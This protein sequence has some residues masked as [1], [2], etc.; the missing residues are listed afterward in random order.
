MCRDLRDDTATQGASIYVDFTPT[1]PRT[2]QQ[3]NS[4]T[5]AVLSLTPC[6]TPLRSPNA[7]FV[8]RAARWLCKHPIETR[9]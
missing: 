8:W 9:Y 4:P 1:T 6:R 2:T 5:D 7:I 3:E